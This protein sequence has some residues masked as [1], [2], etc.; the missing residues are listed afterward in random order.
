MTKYHK[1][2]SEVPQETTVSINKRLKY[3]IAVVDSFWKKWRNEYLVILR[4]FHARTNYRK[5][6]LLNED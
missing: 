5:G 6:G 2:L 3:M 4:D 1:S